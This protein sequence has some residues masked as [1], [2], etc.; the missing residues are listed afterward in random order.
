MKLFDDPLF[1]SPADRAPELI[2]D[3]ALGPTP[4]AT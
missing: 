3:D 2:K 1:R 4:T